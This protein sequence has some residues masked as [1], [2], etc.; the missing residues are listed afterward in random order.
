MATKNQWA[1][2]VT[3]EG[4]G[5]SRH[6]NETPEQ[7]AERLERRKGKQVDTLGGWLEV[8]ER[9]YAPGEGEMDLEDQDEGESYSLERRKAALDELLEPVR[10]KHKPPSSLRKGKGASAH[11]LI[12]LSGAD[13][14]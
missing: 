5:I 7:R 3:N 13:Y 1:G 8:E 14:V 12:S 11:I 2:I 10:T 6:E 4:L 9:E